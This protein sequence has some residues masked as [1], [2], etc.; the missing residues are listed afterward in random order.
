MIV[1]MMVIFRMM[2]TLQKVITESQ[3]K[4]KNP[5]YCN[6]CNILL[7]V[8]F[9]NIITK[10]ISDSGYF[11]F[12]LHIYGFYIVYIYIYICKMHKCLRHLRQQLS[13]FLY[14]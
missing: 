7:V 11:Y 14:L 9:W 6:I 5:K 12:H 1:V 10:S 4:I 2:I 8:P 13:H 3:V